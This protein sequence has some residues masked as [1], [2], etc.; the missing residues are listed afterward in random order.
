MPARYYANPEK[1]RLAKGNYVAEVL[2][3]SLSTPSWYYIVQR[4]GSSK[5]IDLARFDTRERAREAAQQALTR[6]NLG[7]PE[8]NGLA[9][10]KSS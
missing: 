10:P 5:V 1:E 6:L 9:W 4:A 8:F 2:F 7:V 3:S